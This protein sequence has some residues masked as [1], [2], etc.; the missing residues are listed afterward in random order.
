M[1]WWDTLAVAGLGIAAI[2]GGFSLAEIV[3]QILTGEWWD[4]E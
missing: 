3:I 4:R 1:N 2:L